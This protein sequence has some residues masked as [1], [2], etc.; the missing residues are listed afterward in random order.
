MRVS[1]VTHC[2][3]IKWDA[4][5]CIVNFFVIA[6]SVEF[7]VTSDSRT[8]KPIACRV[9]KLEPGSVTFEVSF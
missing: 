5:G 9:L 4:S 3:I 1:G 6:D 8:G 2:K 7:E